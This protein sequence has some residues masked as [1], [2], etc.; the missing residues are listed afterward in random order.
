MFCFNIKNYPDSEDLQ[1][2]EDHELNIW[3]H[4]SLLRI[5]QSVSSGREAEEP[6][7]SKET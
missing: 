5:Y 1:R 4:F 2:R 6:S 3:T 7:K